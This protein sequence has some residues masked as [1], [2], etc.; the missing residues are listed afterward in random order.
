MK[1]ILFSGPVHVLLDKR[2]PVS[3]TPAGYS[4]LIHAL[5]IKVPL[6]RILYATSEK[7]IIMD[8]Q[9][10]RIMTPRYAPKPTVFSHITFALKYEGLDLTVLKRIFLTI[11]PGPV[12]DMIKSSPTGAYARK[13]WFLYEWLLGETLSLANAESGRYVPVVSP[14]IQ[15]TIKGKTSTRHRIHNNLPGSPEFCPMIFKS[16]EIEKYIQMNMAE[17]AKKVVAKVPGDVLARSAAFLLLKDSKAS[18]AIEGEPSTHDRIQRWGK[19]LGQAGRNPLDMEELVRLQRT[20]IKDSRF[21]NMGLRTKGGFVGEHDRETGMPLPEHIS[22][23]PDELKSLVHG[24]MHFDKNTCHELDPVMA[25]ALLTFGFIYIH[26][27]EDG[28]G[29]IHR[30]LIHHVLCAHGFNPPG[31]VFPVSAAILD[32]IEEYRNVLED[33][34]ERLLPAIDWEPTESGNVRVLNDTSD[35]YRFFDATPHVEFLYAC[36]LQTIEKDLPQE[37]AFL[38]KHDQFCIRIES[39]IDMPKQTLNMLFRF[40]RQNQ[41]ALSKRAKNREFSTLTKKETMR[42]ERIYDELFGE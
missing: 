21:V 10:W 2:L 11:G 40:L 17:Q 9:G 3:A 19:I 34:S 26:P 25:A 18:Y 13:I 20:V 16:P 27:F 37:T 35:F 12:E 4:A 29:R 24:L 31:A 1:K 39:M 41:G 32:R 14:E 36:V 38:Q 5:T 28:N 6:P 33:Y 42:I 30:Y 22:A 8:D 23:R 15:W 7:H